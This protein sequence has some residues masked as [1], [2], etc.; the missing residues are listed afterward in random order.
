[1]GKGSHALGRDQD[2]FGQS[3]PAIDAHVTTQYSH[4]V[5]WLEAAYIGAHGHDLARAIAAENVRK[6]WFGWIHPGREKG[7]GGVESCES[8]VQ[9]YLV[10]IG[11]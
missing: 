7:I 8:Y 3:A 4:C 1:V 11:M 10:P 9:E 5:S 2:L 6:T